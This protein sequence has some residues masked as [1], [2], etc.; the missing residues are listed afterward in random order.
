[1]CLE[2]NKQTY[3]QNID[4]PNNYAN[5]VKPSWVIYWALKPLF[6][7]QDGAG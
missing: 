7:V 3:D 5:T 6:M 1:M 2:K 4:L